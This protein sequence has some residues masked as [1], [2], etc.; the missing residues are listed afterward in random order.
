M[1][2]PVHPLTALIVM[3]GAAVL[4]RTA[5]K[6]LHGSAEKALACDD[7]AVDVPGQ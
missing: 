7:G 6:Q 4:C 5:R 2:R 3:A 1:A